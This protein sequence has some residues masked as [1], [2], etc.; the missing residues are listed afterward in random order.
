MRVSSEIVP[1]T[2]TTIRVAQEMPKCATVAI[3]AAATRRR[4]VMTDA[5]AS[6]SHLKHQGSKNEPRIEAVHD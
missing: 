5:P 6:T 4:A 1:K 2:S 3:L